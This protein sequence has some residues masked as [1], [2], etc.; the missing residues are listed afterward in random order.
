MTLSDEQATLTALFQPDADVDVIRQSLRRIG[1]IDDQ[2]SVMTPLPLTDD[3]SARAGI[4]PIYAITIV[5]GIVGIGVGI[6]FAGGTA[7]LYPLA[8]GG[9]PILAAPVIGI[10]S[11][12]TMMLLAIL[13]TFLSTIVV[14]R[15]AQREAVERDTRIDDGYIA[16]SVSGLSRETRT[17]VEPL[18]HD[19]GAV[20]IRESVSTMLRDR[21]DQVRPV[22][23]AAVAAFVL[24]AGIP[25]CSRDMQ[26][27]SSYGPQ[28]PP[29]L[30]SP[31][32]S[33]P[34][35]SRRIFMGTPSHRATTD[36]AT[37]FA[38]N[39][40][41]CHGI[42]GRG[43]GPVSAFLREQ[44]TDLRK[45]DVQAMSESALYEVLTNGKDMMPAF[46]GE[47]SAAERYSVASYVKA[48]PE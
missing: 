44:P 32:S 16:V 1:I 11:Y 28:E 17:V 10:I 14:I 22:T 13:A 38:I 2:V 26:D 20:D 36:G 42:D 3:A 23:A 30:H 47:L 39:C 31:A 8:T 24:L 43:D 25:G 29:R 35:D 45:P 7:A 9:K 48:F 15:G 5:A 41:H 27:Q 18:L 6:F 40:S 34:R 19:A 33:I 12:E 21:A 4:I 37:L 46:R